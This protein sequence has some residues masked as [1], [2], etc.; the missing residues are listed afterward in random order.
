MLILT[1]IKQLTRKEKQ[2]QNLSAVVHPHPQLKTNA[3]S[4]VHTKIK[5]TKRCKEIPGML[6]AYEVG[7]PLSRVS[8]GSSIG[9][10]YGAWIEEAPY[11]ILAYLHS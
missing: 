2:Q 4:L 1:K 9:G 6:Y 10:G 3:L 11:S 7:S 8:C 5:I